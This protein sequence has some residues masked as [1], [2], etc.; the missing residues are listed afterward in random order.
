MWTILP[1]PVLT[2]IEESV[3]VRDNILLSSRLWSPPVKVYDLW[4]LITLSL[5][6]ISMGCINHKHKSTG[7]NSVMIIVNLSTIFSSFL[8]DFISFFHNSVSVSPISFF[9]WTGRLFLLNKRQKKYKINSLLTW[10]ITKCGVVLLKTAKSP[11]SPKARLL[12]RA[13]PCCHATSCWDTAAASVLQHT[14]TFV[15]ISGPV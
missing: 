8:S 13:G 12:Q 2:K 7:A 9:P 4:L 3:I 10:V 1:C 14:L 11:C 6:S 15:G 5:S